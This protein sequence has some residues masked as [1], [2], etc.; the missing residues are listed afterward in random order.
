[1][2]V[3]SEIKRVFDLNVVTIVAS[4]L[5]LFGIDS[6]KDTITETYV[7]SLDD[8]IENRYQPSKENFCHFIIIVIVA[9]L[10]LILV[11]EYWYRSTY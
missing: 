3:H 5:I 9:A 1:M 7:H 8:T 2:G 11:Y 4:G 6:F 10:F